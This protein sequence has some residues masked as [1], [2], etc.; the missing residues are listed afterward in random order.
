[1][2]DLAI[3]GA[4]GSIGTQTLEVVRRFPDRYRVFGLSGHSNIQL[5]I[6]QARE[7][8][9]QV[10]VVSSEEQ[11]RL[12]TEEVKGIEVITGEEGLNSLAEASSVDIVVA[13]IVGTA[14]LTPTYRAIRAGKRVA[15]ANKET[16][17]AAGDIMMAAVSEYKAEL[18]PVDSEH[19]A[20]FQCIQGIRDGELRKV[21]LTASGGPFRGY[22]KEQLENVGVEQA[23]K[24][25]NWNMGAKITIDSATLMNKGLEV[26]EAYWLFGIRNIEVVIHPQSIIH[27]LIETVDG[28]F[29]AQLG[30]PDMKLPIQYALTYP[31]RL[32][33]S[34]EALDLIKLKEMTFSE[35]DTKAFPAL[36]LAYQ[37]LDTGMTMPAVLNAANEVAVGFFLEGRIGFLDIPRL[38]EQTMNAHDPYKA[39][40]I[41]DVLA[42]DNWAREKIRQ[43]A[44]VV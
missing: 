37:A 5:L 33:N 15:L 20:I 16:L 19:S 12:F 23:L 8:K 28:S 40:T 7:F 30:L 22:T 41:S 43:L 17:V 44:E 29:L 4:T 27:S 35:P 2:R 42:A 26:I 10:V 11:A 34:F 32:D 31:Q 6:E 14:G 1:M 24:H 21:I 25:P 9:P 39:R 38:V 13:A 36:A 3:L 18:I